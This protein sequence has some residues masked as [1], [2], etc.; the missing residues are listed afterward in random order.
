MTTTV[1]I[2]T[3]VASTN[4][5]SLLNPFIRLIYLF[6][7]LINVAFLNVI[8]ASKSTSQISPDQTLPINSQVNKKGQIFLIDDGTVRGAN[9]FH[10]FIQF[11][12]PKGV[13]AK[14]TNGANIQNILSRVTSST[15]SSINGILNAA[16]GANLFLINFNGIT[17][18]PNARLNIGGSFIATT[19]QSTFVLDHSVRL[20]ICLNLLINSITSWIG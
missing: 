17:F 4:L 2:C 15:P 3:V 12:I 11:S 13:T 14:F 7:I 20:I 5:L 9:L 8:N 6:K 1:R 16:H 18:D 19:A 10:S